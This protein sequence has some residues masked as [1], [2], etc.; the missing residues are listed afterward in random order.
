ML[1]F[2][3]IESDCSSSFSDTGSK[4]LKLEYERSKAADNYEQKVFVHRYVPL[5]SLLSSNSECDNFFMRNIEKWDDPYEERTFRI[6]ISD[7]S[8]NSVFLHPLPGQV[9]GSC[10]TTGYN[11]EAQWK[12]YEN[13]KSGPIVLIRIELSALLDTLKE[14]DREFYV[15]YVS[16]YDQKDVNKQLSQLFEKYSS[17]FKAF[18]KGDTQNPDQIARMLTPFFIKRQAFSYEREIRIL[19]TDDSKPESG[20]LYI[21]IG[22]FTQLISSITLSPFTSEMW[23]DAQKN[24]LINEG[25]ERVNGNSLRRPIKQPSPII[26]NDSNSMS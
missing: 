7:K 26:I 5:A 16:Y 14:F 9:F 17:T 24:M 21:P 11:A 13:P 12:I 10:F 2:I 1:H 18:E 3:N 20:N 8:D 22:N 6:K 4:N 15:G 25:F 23:R 19:T